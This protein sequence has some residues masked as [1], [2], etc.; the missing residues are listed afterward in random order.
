LLPMATVVAVLI[1][2]NDP[3]NAEITIR[4][5]QAAAGSLGLQLHILNA[6][7]ERDF[8]AAFAKLIQLRADGLVVGGGAF[9]IA[10]T[11]RI[12]GLALGHGMPA[13][14]ENR[15]FVAAGGLAGYGGSLTDSYRH[16]GVYTGRVLKGEKPSELPVQQ[17]MKVEMFLN[18]KTA[19]ALGITVSLPLL[20]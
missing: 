2:T 5:L 19:K 13:V 20:G 16:A 7:S 18:L 1:D 6:S 12:A 14:Y 9:F 15:E 4:D 8:D 17:G 11:E 10:R 3:A